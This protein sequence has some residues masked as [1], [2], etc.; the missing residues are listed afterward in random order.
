M[1]LIRRRRIP[2]PLKHMPQMS[3]TLRTNNL[4]PRHPKRTIRVSRH[5]ARDT[6]KIRRPAAAGFEFMGSAIEG[7][8][9]GDAFL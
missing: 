5:R 3:S 4:G 7:R 2:L 6:V 9:A 8:F 1:P